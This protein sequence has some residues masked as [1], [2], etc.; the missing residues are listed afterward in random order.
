M[1]TSLTIAGEELRKSANPAIVAEAKEV[2]SDWRSHD[3]DVYDSMAFTVIAWH[4]AKVWTLIE[5]P[6]YKDKKTR[7][8][9]VLEVLRDY[10][11][12]KS[13]PQIL[14]A[15]RRAYEEVEIVKKEGKRGESVK[16]V[17][18]KIHI[19]HGRWSAALKALQP[20]K[21]EP[22]VEPACN[23]RCSIHP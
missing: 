1:E 3:S 4:V 8:T 12:S 16:E 20:P 14:S 2:A 18:E 7:R 5:H 9:F 6:R 13:E 23:H 15:E 10:Y 22:V 17:A 11:P 21:Q 19:Q